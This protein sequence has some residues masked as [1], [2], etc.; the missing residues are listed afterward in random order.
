[1][2]QENWYTVT[3]ERRTGGHAVWSGQAST[4]VHAITY[5]EAEHDGTAT[6]VQEHKFPMT[7]RCGRCGAL[8]MEGED[9]TRRKRLNG[10]LRCHACS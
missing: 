2:P 8:I 7:E 5:A 1:M 10:A 3:I 4:Q 6:A 9:T